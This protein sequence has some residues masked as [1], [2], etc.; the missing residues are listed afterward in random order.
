MG[1]AT[2]L[3][4]CRICH[5]ACAVEVDV[6]VEL[7]DKVSTRRAVAV[8]GHR[9][10]PVFEGYTCIKGRQLVEQLDHVERV[11][12]V[13][14]RVGK[15]L[16][17]V[18]QSTALDHIASEL[19]RIIATH[20]P[21]AVASYVGTGGFQASACVPL[22]EAWHKAIDSPSFHTSITI[23]Q[24]A[25][26]TAPL[27]IGWWHGGFHGWTSSDVWMA[28]GVNPIVSSYAP[29]GGL[30]GTN[31]VVE[32][33]RAKARGL[34][35]I[36]IDPRRTEL[37]SQA[38]IHLQVMPGEDAA[39]LAG[40]LRLILAEGW[41][42]REFCAAHVNGV[43]ELASAVESFT[44]D[45][46]ADRCGISVT[47]FVAATELFAKASR[48]TAGTGTG[49]NMA[50]RAS[51]TEHLAIALNVVCGRVNRVG[52]QVDNPGVLTGV[53]ELRAEVIA[54][55]PEVLDAGPHSRIPGKR[56]YR[57][58]LPTNV[59]ADEILTEGD[60]QVRA[61][62]V[63]G[64]NP[65]VAW[66]DQAKTIAAM[67]DLE[68]LVVID[69][70]QTA[71]TAF[72]D[73]VI[74]A[75]LG[76]ERSDVTHIMDRWF[77][78]PYLHA[79]NDVVDAPG[80]AMAEWE[81]LWEI[82]ARMGTNVQ[83]PGGPLPINAKPVDR[84]VIELLFPRTAVPLNERWGRGGATAEMVALV[85]EP[86]RPGA[87]ARFAV[88]PSDIVAELAHLATEDSTLSTVDGYDPS[89]HRYRLVSRRDQQTLNS[90]GSELP[91]SRASGGTTNPAW[92][93][94]DD[95]VELGVADGDLVD[96]ASP[97][98]TVR[99]VAQSSDAV[100]RKVVS[101]AHSWGGADLHDERVRDIGTP[102]NRLVDNLNGADVIT[103]QA[104][105]SAIPVQVSAVLAMV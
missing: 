60:G 2:E 52:D 53:K 40:M 66:P 90:L 85:V 98:G 28:I 49:P 62:I 69:H 35:L 33:R 44:P 5:A 24:P 59:L 57:G 34:K 94:P 19:E 81:L 36:V 63:L 30:Q 12:Q 58:Q 15:E 83:L 16:V 3:S 14:Q 64:G 97:R 4:F 87:D 27:R 25:K 88:A 18:D 91:R 13:M 21:R 48:G 105:Q 101:M 20:G 10:D 8:R 42:D 9:S 100:R 104:V 74:P 47:D 6:A 32:L 76:L 29:L 55:M 89:I 80:D 71:T 45:V 68:L 56:G 96:I 50:P 26:A 65:V 82:A 103:G 95:L 84:T 93:H 73:W 86:A 70:R 41:H 46:V 78:T 54:P 99:A 72:A 37:A 61:L 1:T 92:M 7:I 39:L 22:T 23:D 79:T 38:E 51:L 75:K 102:T 17:P 43:D 31:P 67:N 77:A 11:T